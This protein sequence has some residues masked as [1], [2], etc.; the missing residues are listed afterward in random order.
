MAVRQISQPAY[1]IDL[2]G[3]DHLT[4]TEASKEYLTLPPSVQFTQERGSVLQSAREA[5]AFRIGANGTLDSNL[6]QS[7]RTAA[8]GVKIDG[9][10]YIA[11]DDSNDPTQN[12][13]LSRAQD[14]YNAHRNTN[15]WL[16]P[17]NNPI[18]KAMLSRAEQ[19]TRIVRA[20]LGSLE[21]S[22]IPGQDDKSGYGTHPL[23][24]AILGKDLTECVATYFLSKN[25]GNGYVWALSPANLAKLG[26][27]DD[28]VEVRR[29]GVGGSDDDMNYLDAGDRCDN[30]GRARGVRENSTGNKGGC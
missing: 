17:R 20:P 13:L 8:I 3:F 22:A 24:Q 26:V 10:Y 28:N 7:T 19:G 21:L 25:F 4:F 18:I 29:V 12:I 9:D 15:R 5:W 11:I 23:P 27:D 2:L 1:A 16:V 30:Y 6:Y 14:G